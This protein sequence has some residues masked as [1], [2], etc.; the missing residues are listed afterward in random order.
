MT[1]FFAV[2]M[3]MCIIYTN[4]DIVVF[5]KRLVCII[6]INKRVVQDYHGM[7]YVCVYVPGITLDILGYAV[8]LSHVPD[9]LE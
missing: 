3:Y 2:Y 5:G 9:C 7:F 6:L 8:A 1:K 4:M